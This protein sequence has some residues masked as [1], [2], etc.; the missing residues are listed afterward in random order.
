MNLFFNPSVSEFRKLINRAAKSKSVH[1]LVIDYDG[2]VLIDPQL[3]QPQLELDRFKVHV[4]LQ[5]RKQIR[6]LFNHILNA[7]NE[8]LASLS[9]HPEGLS[10]Q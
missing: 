3:D 10:V 4:R 8:N 6:N 5:G 2:E 1:D 9:R 7:W